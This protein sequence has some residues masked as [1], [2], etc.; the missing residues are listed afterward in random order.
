[1]KAHLNV[2]GLIDVV[3]GV[4]CT[5]MAVLISLGVLLFARWFTGEP[6]LFPQLDF[7]EPSAHRPAAVV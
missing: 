3:A 2:V 6:T 1:M 7:S 5:I 4:F